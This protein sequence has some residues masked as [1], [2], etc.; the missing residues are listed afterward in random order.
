[1]AGWILPFI[2]SPSQNLATMTVK[3]LGSYKLHKDKEREWKNRQWQERNVSQI[4]KDGKWMN[5]VI[6]DW[7]PEPSH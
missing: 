7:V 2:F 3:G 6:T 1:M 5:Q 4:L